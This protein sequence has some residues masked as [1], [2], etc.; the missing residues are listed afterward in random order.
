MKLYFFGISAAL[1]IFLL[2]CG[3]IGTSPGGTANA[4]A[5]PPSAPPD[6]RPILRLNGAYATSSA[7]GAPVENLFDQDSAT[8]WRTRAGAGPDE[9]IMLYFA[10]PATLQGVRLAGV[11]DVPVTVYE[12]GQ[13]GATGGLNREIALGNK[14]LRSLYLRFG[15]PTGTTAVRRTVGDRNIDLLPFP[16]TGSVGLSRLQL[17]NASGEDLRIVAPARRTGECRASSTLSPASAYGTACLFDARREFA[18]VEGNPATDGVGEMLQFRFPVNTTITALEI[19][20]GYQRSDEHFS[21]NARVRAFSFGPTG[22]APTRYELKDNQTPQKIVLEKP[23]EGNTFDLRIESVFPGKKYKDLAISELL[24]YNGAEAFVPVVAAVSGIAGKISDS[25]LTAILDKRVA[26]SIREPDL[27]A[28]QAI[29]LRTDGTFVVYRNEKW[30]DGAG[31][32]IVADGNWEL[33]S[34]DTRSARVKIFG[35]LT[36]V[37]QYDAYYKG[38]VTTRFTRIFKDEL[39]IDGATIQG[40]DFIQTLYIR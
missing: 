7:E 25:P 30:T 12:N 10:E 4:P 35:K 33:L 6:A 19:R 40:K 15:A 21:A 27:Q 38:A 31:S 13:P 23:V 26:N 17:F 32:E 9:G 29:I 3:P 24:F 28:E 14:P 8:V 2:R 1:L 36:D 16:G 39:T 37:S 11:P 20:N 34:A 18:W 5:T 22:G